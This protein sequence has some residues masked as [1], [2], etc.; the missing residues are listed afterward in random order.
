MHHE[1]LAARIR[2]LRAERK[3][4]ILAHVYTPIEVQQVADYTGDSL[5]LSRK[6]AEKGSDH[7]MIVFCGVRFMAE[8][9]AILSPEKTVVVPDPDA[10]CPMADMIT[11]EAVRGLRR[12]NPDAAVACYVNSTVEVKAECDVCV[13]SANAV[14]IVSRLPQRRVVFVPD[15]CLGAWVQR[16]CPDKELVLWPGF[17]PT[18][19]RIT[20]EHVAAARAAHPGAVVMAH[21]ECSM[22]VLDAADFIGSTGQMQDHAKT[23]GASSFVVASEN[24]LLARLAL[25][26]PGK[27]FFPVTETAVCPNMKRSTLPLVLDALENA[28]HV[29]RVD[30]VVGKRALA[31]INRMFELS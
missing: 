20:P 29:V 4:V 31:A 10:G 1:E 5:G 12:E 11:A 6:A 26:N 25:D 13:T 15:E 2:A 19:H 8:T 28:T 21:P 23:S 30:P 24:G 16:K 3:A 14:K 7:R 18:H 27:S 22:S 17:C 9:A